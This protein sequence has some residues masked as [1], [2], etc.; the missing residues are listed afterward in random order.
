MRKKNRRKNTNKKC[1]FFDG[2]CIKEDC[3]IYLE[4]LDRCAIPVIPYNMFKLDNGIRLL[5]DSEGFNSI[6]EDGGMAD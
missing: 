3:E 1:P 2:F 4:K 6:I 5:I